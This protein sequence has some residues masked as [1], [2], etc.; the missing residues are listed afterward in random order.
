ML[1]AGLRHPM[2]VALALI[3][4]MVSLAGI[5]GLLGVHFV[6]VFQVLIYVGAVM[7][8][9]VYVI[10]LLDVREATGRPALLELLLPGVLGFAAAGG[11]ARRQRRGA[12][13]PAPAAA[14]GDAAYGITQPFS[15]DVPAASTG[16]ISS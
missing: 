12:D 15:V 8:F 16:C 7:V 3:T 4:T 11:H 6:A 5:Y 10:M 13:R 1:D 2:R 9:M 14:T